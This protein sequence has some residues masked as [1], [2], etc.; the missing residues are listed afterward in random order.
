VGDVPP[1]TVSADYFGEFAR[2]IA[3][4]LG[5]DASFVGLLTN[6]TSGD[7]NN[8]NFLHPRP[9][10]PVFERIRTVA[11]RV[12]D[13][14]QEACRKMSYQDRAE[15]AM[16]EREIRLAVR[17]A[18]PAELAAARAM[19]AEKDEKKVPPLA[20]YYAQTALDMDQWPDTVS[21][22]LQAIRIGGLGIVS[23]PN[24][25]FAEVGLEL[26]RRSPLR[27]MFTVDLAN[28]YNG[29]LPTP[30][31]HALGGYETWRATSSSLEVEA[32]RKITTALLDM[33]AEVAGK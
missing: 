15:L 22:K 7:V 14:A 30:E 4:R 24:E 13:A 20:H 21:L 23:M 5:G 16:V 8:V 12:A 10:V 25:A 3:Q 33:L 2:Q 19:L 32:S 27:P 29:Y 31:Q 1:G 18:S 6:G 11:A 17:K 9:R 28:G 26:K